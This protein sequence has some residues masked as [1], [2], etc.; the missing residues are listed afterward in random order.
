MMTIVCELST[1]HGG[2]VD[3]AC[4][5][6]R[7][8]SDAGA[9][10]AK[11]QSYSLA[12][13]HGADPQRDWLTQA[14][15]DE[16]AHER[17]RRACEDAGIAFLST[18]FDEDSLAMLRRMGVK[19]FKIA[20]SEAGNPW[21]YKQDGETWFVSWPWGRKPEHSAQADID[22]AA[23]PLYPTPLEC[24][25]R[26]HMR[27]GWSDHGMGLS[28][29]LMQIAH[30]VQL[31]EA[32]LSLDGRG[33]TCVWDK[34]PAEFRQLRDFADACATMRSGVSTVYRRRWSA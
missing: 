26:A 34:S 33:R 18:P 4:D 24:V 14:H 10:Y 25:S 5:M 2:D 30:G 11:I 13:L 19:T 31:V 16:A 22:I 23:I 21:W 3:L 20:S 29:C 17:I 28:A 9:D 15:L 1:N 8:A 27:Q 12:R 6:V 32:H 7:A